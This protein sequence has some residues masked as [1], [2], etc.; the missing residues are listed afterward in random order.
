[1]HGLKKFMVLGFVM[2]AAAE[3]A[4]SPMFKEDF[5]S[6]L[7]ARWKPVKFSDE[8]HYEILKD[9]T[10]AYLKGTASAAA[11]GLAVELNVTPKDGM[12]FSWKW[13]IDKTPPGASDDT[14]KTFDHT[15]RLF[16]A[17][18]TLIGP[19]RTVNYVWA[20]K[21]AA[22]Q[23]F[24]HPSSGRS[25]CIAV[26]SGN[27]KAGEW[28]TEKRDVVRDWKTLFGDDEPPQI[29]GI[30]FMTDSDGTASTVTGC[31]DDIV[32]KKEGEEK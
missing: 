19:P 14:K 28:I 23:T 4:D 15:A 20:N 17:F 6:G 2:I 29:V 26:E 8:T 5:Q 3:A 22:G 25:R 32:L 30:G 10:N 1:M 21:V 24:H 11:T 16:I 18:K 12:Q 9:G 7:S 31:Y 13:K 27:S